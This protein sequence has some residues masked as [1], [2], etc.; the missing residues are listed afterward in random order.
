MNNNTKLGYHHFMTVITAGV[1]STDVGKIILL[2][3]TI[4]NVKQNCCYMF[5]AQ[6]NFSDPKILIT[7]WSLSKLVSNWANS[8]VGWEW[9]EVR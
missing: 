1:Q 9:G 5:S 8:T 6:V 2:K 4:R 7:Y 3:N